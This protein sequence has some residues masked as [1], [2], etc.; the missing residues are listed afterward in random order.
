MTNLRQKDIDTLATMLEFEQ[1][2][3]ELKGLC[4]PTPGD[5]SHMKR[6]ERLGMV[7]YIGRFPIHLDFW[8]AYMMAEDSLYQTYEL[9]DRG[10][11]FGY[12]DPIPA[13]EEEGDD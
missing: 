2:N 1:S 10:R 5:V 11:K 4:A 6:L 9:T 13:P 8:D 7:K 3:E 12:L